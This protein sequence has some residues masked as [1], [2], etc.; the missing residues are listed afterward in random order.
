MQLIILFIFIS[1][2]FE[3]IH[4][5]IA[6]NKLGRYVLPIISYIISLMNI[7]GLIIYN[8]HQDKKYGSSVGQGFVKELPSYVIMFIIF[9]IPTIIF[10]ITNIFIKKQNKQ[11]IS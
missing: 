11:K 2:P 3:L 9:N 5:L 1:L 10:C 6:K 4:I 7:L 8:I